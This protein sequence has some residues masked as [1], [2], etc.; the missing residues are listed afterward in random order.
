MEKKQE[1]INYDS[2]FKDELFTY[3]ERIEEL[4]KNF[5]KTDKEID[6]RTIVWANNK[7][8][9]KIKLNKIKEDINFLKTNIEDLKKTFMNIV[10]ELKF[11][12]NKE[13]FDL[14]NKKIENFDYLNFITRRDFIELVEK[15]LNN[16]E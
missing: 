3:L 4:E 15:E 8:E 14:L 1:Q 6:I 13:D 5:Q 9:T 10:F 7:N 2:L 16:I 12:S 11:S